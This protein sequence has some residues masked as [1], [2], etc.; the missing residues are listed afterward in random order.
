MVSEH[1]GL[2]LEKSF[3]PRLLLPE[4]FVYQ[5]D[6]GLFGKPSFVSEK[7]GSLLKSMTRISGQ[8]TM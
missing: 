7:A 8:N 2:S 6:D 4:V 1:V 3:K 5:L